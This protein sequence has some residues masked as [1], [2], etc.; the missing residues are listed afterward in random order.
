MATRMEIRPRALLAG[1]GAARLAAEVRETRE[2]G[3]D[4]IDVTVR[5]DTGK[6]LAVEWIEL[7]D[8]D[9]GAPKV[10][11]FRQGFHM[12]S[13]PSG[14][15]V[16]EAGQKP[17]HDSHWRPEGL[18][19]WTF[20]SHTVA[21]AAAPGRR[22][23]LLLGFVEN[24]DYEG[25]LHFRTRGKSV[26]VLGRVRYE[27]I[28]IAPGERVKMGRLMKAEHADFTRLVET[29]AD[30]T[31]R[32]NRARVPKTTPAGWSDWQFYR[33]HKTEAHVM[34]SVRAMAPLRKAGWPL[35]H[36]V[37]DNG[38]CENFSEW[39]DPCRAFP[40]GMKRLSRTMRRYGFKLG[41]WLA[42]YL[43]NDKTRVVREHPDWLAL[44]A[45]TG[46]PFHRPNSNVGPCGVIDF[47]VPEAMD[48]LRHVVRVMVREWKIG[49]L[50][51]D[52]P[53]VGHYKGAKLHDPKVTTVQ[54]IRRTLELI[55]EECGEDVIV[56]GEGLYGPSI[57]MVDVQ[58]T[59]QDNHPCWYLPG[60][61]HPSMKENLKN[62]LLSGFLHNRFWRNHRENVLLRDFLSPFHAHRG[63]D[64]ESK[65]VMLTDNELIFQVSATAFGG[66]PQLLTAPM[67]DLVRSP[68]RLDIAAR[69]LPHAEDAVASVLDAF[70]GGKQPSIYTIRIE[71]P[72]ESW[73]VVGVFNWED[74][75]QDFTVPLRS[76]AGPGA[77]HVFDFWNETYL[78][79]FAG[80]LP[81]RDVPAHGCRVL[82]V[83]QDL[84]RPQLVGDN[85]HLF[86]GAVE[87]RD[88]SFEKDTL[89]L[90]LRHFALDRRRVFIAH[91]RRYRL[92][93]VETKARDVLVDDRRPELLAIEFSGKRN[94]D[95]AIRW[96]KT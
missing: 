33:E 10:E 23:R 18:D 17:P 67:A 29:Y 83:R 26:R 5:N 30:H 25:M 79:K 37:L 77:W 19:A 75:H 60:S 92:R 52:G 62:D 50:K 7:F 69:L 32:H 94:V 22:A 96:E 49:Y 89:R 45:K 71:R 64:G 8:L 34:A 38:W 91:P 1:G 39:L 54:M 48:W 84:D 28:E 88:A 35:E 12:P 93:K 59:T 44:D 76:V 70:R 13:D 72:F 16:L 65:D 27:G 24:N 31:A 51:L 68:K 78:G 80:R 87:L 86:Q 43:A 3:F 90:K 63:P 11:V 40:S 74:A 15:T 55:R 66:G 73:S 56:E 82:A 9:L 58:R 41:L 20:T 6:P 95:L 57:G 81:V 2:S 53:C 46:K 61:G 4:L 21:V 14:F 85:I 36:I 47:T 42:P